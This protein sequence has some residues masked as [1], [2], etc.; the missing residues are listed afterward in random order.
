MHGLARCTT[1][2]FIAG[3]NAHAEKPQA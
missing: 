3:R 2:G 1:Q